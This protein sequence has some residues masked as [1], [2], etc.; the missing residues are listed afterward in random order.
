MKHLLSKISGNK[1]FS[2]AVLLLFCAVAAPVSLKIGGIFFCLGIA[3]HIYCFNKKSYIDD[4][5][6]GVFASIS[7]HKDVQNIQ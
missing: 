2:L 7:Y 4:E 3:L 6:D 5:R 1:I